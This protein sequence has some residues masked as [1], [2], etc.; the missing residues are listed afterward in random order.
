MIVDLARNDLGRVCESGSVAGARRCA[1]S[2]RT[3]GLHHL[4]STVR[5]RLRADVGTRRRSC[6][7]T[8]PPASVTGA[9]E[10]ARAAGDRGPRA[11]APRRVLRRGR[12]DRH[13][14]RRA[15]SSRSR[16]ARS[17]VADG[18]TDLG[19]GGGIVA[20]SEPDA[21]W[22]E[23]ELKAARL[24]AAAGARAEP[25]ARRDRERMSTRDRLARRRA[26]RRSTTARVSPFDHGLLVGDGVFETLRVYGGVP[27]AWPATSTRLAH[28]AAGLGLAVPDSRRRCAPRPTRCSR[29]TGSREARLRITV[30]GGLAPL[31]LRARRRCRPT[32]IVAASALDAVAADRRRR[33]SCRGRATSAAR[34]PG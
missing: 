5:G 34:P 8:F 23:T 33:R 24:L 13:R 10:A 32:V 12:L 25:P 3:P 26:R 31:G 4:V 16:S 17:R 28:S 2:R 29:R 6:A 1:R 22:A 15:A 19:V 27:F 9:P 20:D 21:E 18:R 11:G 30:T 7:A 14:P